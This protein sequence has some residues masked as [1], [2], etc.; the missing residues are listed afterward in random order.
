MSDHIAAVR[1]Q[2]EKWLAIEGY[3]G[4]YEVSDVE[5]LTDRE[6][7]VA[8]VA[9]QG[10]T[11]RFIADQLHL[12]KRTVETHLGRIYRKLDVSSRDELI[13]LRVYGMTLKSYDEVRNGI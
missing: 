6:R 4:H 11:S 5:Q 1:A 3:E 7:E 12:S 10:F 2:A 9:S 8:E 13:Q